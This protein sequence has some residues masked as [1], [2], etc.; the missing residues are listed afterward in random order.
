M[1][2]Q[3]KNSKALRIAVSKGGLLEDAL[4][5][6]AEMGILVKEFDKRKLLVK[7]EDPD[8]EILLVR[9]HDVPTYVEN[10]AADL[11]IVGSDVVVESQADVMQLKDLKFGQ[12]TLSVCAKKGHYKNLLDLPNH[13]RVATTF[14]N[15]SKHFFHKNDLQVENIHLYGSVELGPLTGLSDVIVDLVATGKTLKENGLEVVEDIMECSARLIANQA[16]YRI[17]KG[18]ISKLLGNN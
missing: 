14:P 6:L 18:K 5:S 8:W 4:K 16:S 9:G 11:G 1:A 17:N 10:G 7:T 3:T 12:C 15:I 2:T 13:A